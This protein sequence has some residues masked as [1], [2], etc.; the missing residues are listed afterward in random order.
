MHCSHRESL[1][2][3]QRKRAGAPGWLKELHGG[4]SPDAG[5]KQPPAISDRLQRERPDQDK[6][7]QTWQR[8]AGRS[9]N[10]DRELE[11]ERG[12]YVALC[13]SSR[14][15]PLGRKASC[16]CRQRNIEDAENRR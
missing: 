2:L 15:A 14:P 3:Q 7:H 13:D 8:E 10:Q 16:K 1:T 11:N 12:S 4:I 9:E 5:L 6:Q